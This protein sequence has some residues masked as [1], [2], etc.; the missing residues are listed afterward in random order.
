M[1]RKTLM[2]ARF[3]MKLFTMPGLHQYK[4]LASTVSQVT[5]LGLQLLVFGR[6]LWRWKQYLTCGLVHRS[7]NKATAFNSIVYRGVDIPHLNLA[8]HTRNA[9]KMDTA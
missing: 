7:V 1:I 5:H 3:Y 2:Q 8:C 9:R 6:L 4:H